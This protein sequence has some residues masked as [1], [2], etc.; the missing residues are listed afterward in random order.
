MFRHARGSHRWKK[1]GYRIVQTTI[2]CIW[3]G[4]NEV[5]FNRKQRKT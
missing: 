4:R 2:W 1:L 5:V 3:R